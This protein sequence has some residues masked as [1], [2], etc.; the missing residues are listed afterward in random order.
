MI[1]H[2]SVVCLV[3]AAVISGV[4]TANGTD[5]SGPTSDAGFISLISQ[6]RGA[7]GPTEE[8]STAFYDIEAFGEEQDVLLDRG[9]RAQLPGAG[10][11]LP[12]PVPVDPDATPLAAPSTSGVGSTA[13]FGG[14]STRAPLAAAPFALVWPVP[15]GSI[16]QYFHAGHLALDIAAPYGS[17]VV[18]AQGARSRGPDGATTAAAT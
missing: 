2:V 5:G 11:P 1:A 16:S 3:F 7:A 9:S 8:L 4:S 12:T 17:T 14:A 10:T 15:A 18:A 13:S 6:A